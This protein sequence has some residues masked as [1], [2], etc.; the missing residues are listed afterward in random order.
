MFFSEDAVGLKNM[1]KFLE[2]HRAEV[3]DMLNW[4]FTET[5]RQNAIKEGKAEGRAEVYAEMKQINLRRAAEMVRQKKFS[6][7]AAAKFFDVEKREL[8]KVLAENS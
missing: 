8:K 1:L 6:V 3:I 4:E 2:E 7:A 5:D